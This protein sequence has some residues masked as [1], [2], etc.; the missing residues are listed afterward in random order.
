MGNRFETLVVEPLSGYEP[1]IGVM[2]WMLESGRIW[3]YCNE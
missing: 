1:E 2:L 3:R